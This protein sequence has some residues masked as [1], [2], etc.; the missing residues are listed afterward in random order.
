MHEHWRLVTG[1][2]EESLRENKDEKKQA[3]RAVSTE[4][5]IDFGRGDYYKSRKE[6]PFHLSLSV[7]F[8][9]R[10]VIL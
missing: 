2:A 9:D 10:L 4:F 3:L 7:C 1:V 5:A 6:F 8:A